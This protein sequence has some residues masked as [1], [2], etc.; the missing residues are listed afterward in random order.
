[1][2]R[3]SSKSKDLEI[4]PSSSTSTITQD[5]LPEEESMDITI[6]TIYGVYHTPKKKETIHLHLPF[7]I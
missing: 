4:S 6:P 7:L 1:M 5:E 3:N 2:T